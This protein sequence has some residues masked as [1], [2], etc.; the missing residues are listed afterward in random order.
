MNPTYETIR[1]DILEQARVEMQNA[2]HWAALPHLWKAEQL[3][4]GANMPLGDKYATL[5]R[6]AYTGQLR[7]TMQKIVSY[8]KRTGRTGEYNLAWEKSREVARRHGIN[9]TQLEREVRGQ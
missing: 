9:F 8:E 3:A 4:R 2:G 5:A 6:E 7:D 1:D